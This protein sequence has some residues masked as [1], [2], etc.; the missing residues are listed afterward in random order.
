MAITTYSELQTA[1]A[2]WIGDS[3]F[4]TDR[5]KELIA[6]AEAEINDEIRTLEMETRATLS[7]SAEY[8]A[9]PDDFGGL[10]SRPKLTSTEPA[11]YLEYYTPSQIDTVNLSSETGRPRVYTIVDESLRV[12]PS[13]DTAYTTEISYFLKVPSL[14]DSTTTNWLLTSRPHIYLYG[15]LAQAEGLLGNDARLMGWKALFTGAMEKLRRIDRHDRF[16]GSPLQ[17]TSDVRI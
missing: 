5:A 11:Y 2:N 16:S 14:S 10:R 3:S 6:L 1:I 12:R 9:L 7:I 8:S 17:M 13:P 4:S 15:A